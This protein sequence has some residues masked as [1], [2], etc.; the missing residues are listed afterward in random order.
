MIQIASTAAAQEG[1]GVRAR[2]VELPDCKSAATLA[3]PDIELKADLSNAIIATCK[4][5]K[6]IYPDPVPAVP[7]TT[8]R[9]D[10]QVY[11]PV[12]HTS[13]IIPNEEHQVTI[14]EQGQVDPTGQGNNPVADVYN[15]IEQAA[16]DQ[17]GNKELLQLS[18]EDSSKT[19]WV[20]LPDCSG[21]SGEIPLVDDVEF[22]HSPLNASSATCKTRPAAGK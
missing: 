1:S 5:F 15:G 10:L 14:Q 2:W 3:L 11:D 16:R 8:R 18:R 7:D 17:A 6:G 9:T 19:Q 22:G 12:I 21:A 13:I 4:V 20:E